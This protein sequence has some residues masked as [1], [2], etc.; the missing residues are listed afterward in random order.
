[1]RQI[2]IS[3]YCIKNTFLNRWRISMLQNT[4]Y[5]YNFKKENN[6]VLCAM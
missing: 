4:H 3:E 5:K 6:N 2:N 1:M